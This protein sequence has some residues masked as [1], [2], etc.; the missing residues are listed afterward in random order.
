[1]GGIERVSRIVFDVDVLGDV[2]CAIKELPSLRLF[3]Q[4]FF[5]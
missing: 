3:L 2:I 4:F 5:A 1:V